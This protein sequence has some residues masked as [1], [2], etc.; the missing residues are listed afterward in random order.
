MAGI[1]GPI[2]RRAM[3]LLHDLILMHMLISALIPPRCV[4]RCRVPGPCP[5]VWRG[6]VPKGDARLAIPQ[7]ADRIL[8]AQ[9]DAE[10]W[11]FRFYPS[12]AP[13]LKE[14]HGFVLSEIAPLL[15]FYVQQIR[16]RLLGSKHTDQLFLDRRGGGI[17]GKIMRARVLNLT[18]QFGGKAV[19]PGSIRE[20][21]SD[22]WLELFPEDFQSLADVLWMELPSVLQKY[23]HAETIV[24]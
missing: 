8:Q 1:A 9:P 2:L 16:P 11:L 19:V 18:R 3:W 6:P 24:A 7:S 4:A 23:V 15:E 5:N 22:Y 13:N 10:F 14:A 12:D 20:S 21:F 17:T